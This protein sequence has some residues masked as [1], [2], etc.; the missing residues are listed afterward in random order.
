MIPEALKDYRQ[1][2]FVIFDLKS[3]ERESDLEIKMEV[4]GVH[5]TELVSSFLDWLFDMEKVYR[6]PIPE[7]ILDAFPD[8]DDEYTID[9]CD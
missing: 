7:E 5:S 2:Q 3:G 6:T 9:V 8:E 4:N 1:E